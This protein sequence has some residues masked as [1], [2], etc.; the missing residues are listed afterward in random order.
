MTI[1]EYEA[2]FRHGPSLHQRF[3][4]LRGTA[5]LRWAWRPVLL[6]A[7]ASAC[8]TIAG[9]EVAAHQTAHHRPPPGAAAHSQP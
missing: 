9:L 6:A 5:H 2:R 1:E 4:Q 7:V 3:R 8:L